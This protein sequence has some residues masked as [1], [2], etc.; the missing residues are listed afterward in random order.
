[1]LVNEC[2]LDDVEKLGSELE[3][4]GTRL[5]GL[6]NEKRKLERRIQAL[7]HRDSDGK[8]DTP[9]KAGGLMSRTASKAVG[10]LVEASRRAR[11][12]FRV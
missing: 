3:A 4:L 8:S 2:E 10:S 12:G 6:E 7:Q 11:L 9:R 1:V 5:Q